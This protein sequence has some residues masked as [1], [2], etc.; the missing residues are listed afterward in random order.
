MEKISA[1][2]KIVN[3]I[4]G[5]CYVG[6]SKDVKRRWK[7]HKCPSKW[8]EQPNS[9]LY[10]D[11]QKYGVDNFRFQ[12]LAPV[13]E[14]YLKQVEQDF[15]ETLNPTYNDLRAKGRDVERIKETHKKCN[16]KYYSQL[17]V[18]NGE[19]LTLKALSHRFRRAGIEHSDIEA[20]K[21]LLEE[22]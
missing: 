10:Q 18:Y 12:I 3:T 1:V 14:H 13:M 11:F 2:Y 22:K 7:E 19:K 16:R 9:P 8:K 5:D 4:T 6:S 15:I 17:C 21:Y 20:K